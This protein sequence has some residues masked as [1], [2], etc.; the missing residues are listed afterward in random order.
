MFFNDG[1]RRIGEHAHARTH[2]HTHTSRV[3]SLFCTCKKSAIEGLHSHIT[4]CIATL[5]SLQVLFSKLIVL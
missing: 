3:P 1:V 2:T 5:V 4:L